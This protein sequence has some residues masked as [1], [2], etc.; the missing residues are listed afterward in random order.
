MRTKEEVNPSSLCFS[1]FLPN[2]LKLE[3][4]LT[5]YTFIYS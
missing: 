5:R 2:R 4:D 1:V 3:K